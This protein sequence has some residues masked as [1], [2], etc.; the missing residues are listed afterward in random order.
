MDYSVGRWT[1]FLG[2]RHHYLASKPIE[3]QIK[4]RKWKWIGYT[5]RKDENAV[6]RIALGWNRQ[7]MRKSRRPKKTWRRSV[8]EEAQG[9][10]KTWREV[11][12][13]AANRSRWKSFVEATGDNRK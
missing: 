3:P 6:E 8:R 1:I 4:K 12:R 9:E 11:K 10:G 2:F 13:L 5:I 7:G